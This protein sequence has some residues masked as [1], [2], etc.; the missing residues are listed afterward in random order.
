MTLAPILATFSRSVVS[1]HRST[2][3]GNTGRAR[4]A[5]LQGISIS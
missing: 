1:D 5:K 4:A 2:S 3:S